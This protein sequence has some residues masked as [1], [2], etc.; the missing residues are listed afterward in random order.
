M[1]DGSDNVEFEFT[2]RGG[3]EDTCINLDLFDTRAVEFFESCNNARLLACAGRPVHEE[4]WEVA[5]LRLA[6]AM[7][8]A[9]CLVGNLFDFLTRARRR[10]ESSG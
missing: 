8:D 7:L 10:S 2:V 1:I 9:K 4:M 6:S 5:A 3:L